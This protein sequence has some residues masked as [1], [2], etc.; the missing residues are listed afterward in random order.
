MTV[1]WFKEF[2]RQD[3]D[4]PH[5]FICYDDRGEYLAIANS[6]PEAVEKVIEYSRITA[7]KSW[8]KDGQ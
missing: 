5:R 3:P 7:Q 4:N 2:I 6:Y 8:R 1:P